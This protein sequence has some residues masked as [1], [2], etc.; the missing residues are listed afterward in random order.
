MKVAFYGNICNNFY[1]MAKCL[2]QEGIADAHLYLHPGVDI[3]NRPESDDPQLSN[4]Y[5]SWIHMDQ[6][7]NTLPFLKRR[8]R[9]FINELNQYDVV[10]LS[11]FGPFLAPYLKGEVFFFATGS[12]LT[13]TPFPSYHTAGYKTIKDR[14]VWEYIG[15]L[16]RRG[17]RAADKV[18]SQPFFPFANALKKLR[19]DPLKV[20]KAYYP[21]LIDTSVIAPVQNAAENIEDENIEKLKKFKFVIFHPSRLVIRKNRKLV[22]TGHWKG[23]DNLFRALAIFK[24]EFNIHDICIALPD[25]KYSADIDIAKKIITELNIEDSVVWLKPST[26]E[27]FP[28]KQLMS[29]YS[30]ADLIADEFATGWF[31]LVVLEGLACG[32][33]TLCYVD[34]AVM[35]RLYPWHPIQSAKEPQKLAGLI[36]KFYFN[37]EFKENI[38]KS[39]L[40]WIREFHSFDAGK[41]IYLANLKADL[42]RD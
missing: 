7:W 26:P 2:R 13:V 35:R 9:R 8:D 18:I 34:D 3:Q 39:S 17:I 41:K 5:P 4:A 27:G 36:S 11:E 19:V 16:Q 23:N 28:R 22:D 15:L 40:D 33:P 29:Y 32:K 25:R 10:F 24:S 6:A 1:T 30:Y 42:F 21:F 37:P 14:L 20:S 31:G 38:G 12:D